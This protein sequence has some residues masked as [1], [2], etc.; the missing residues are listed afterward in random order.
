M[1]SR[2][3]GTSPGRDTAADARSLARRMSKSGYDRKHNGANGENNCDGTD[4]NRSWNCGVEGPTADPGIDRL[5][6]RQ[7]KNFLTASRCSQ[8]GCP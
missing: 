6:P 5:R 1:G 3:A 4:H 2:P 7:V 8:W